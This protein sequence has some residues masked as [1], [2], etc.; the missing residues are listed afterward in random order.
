MPITG[1]KATPLTRGMA[2][3]AQ[4]RFSPD[5]KQVVFV[6]DRDGGWNVWTMS[7]DKRDTVQISRGKTNKYESPEWTPDG[8][9]I[10]ATRDKK[11]RLYHDDGGSGSS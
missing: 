6:S 7:L 2:F 8:Q 5:G 3:D 10:V 1:G 9:Y 11:L 4:P